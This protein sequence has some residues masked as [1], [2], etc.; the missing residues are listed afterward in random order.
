VSGTRTTVCSVLALMMGGSPAALADEKDARAELRS[1]RHS[2]EILAHMDQPEGDRSWLSHHLDR[3]HLH[4]RSGLEYRR[5]LN[6][7]QR[8]IELRVRAPGLKLKRKR[9]GMS[10]EVRF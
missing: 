8:E 10:F 1:I 5:P 7:G 2:A 6:I 9:L 3:V 4:K